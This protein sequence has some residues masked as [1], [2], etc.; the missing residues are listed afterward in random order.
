MTSSSLIDPVV[1]H[2][3]DL[4]LWEA[5][6]AAV[7]AD[8]L[9]VVSPLAARLAQVPDPRRPRGLRHPLLVILVLTACATLVVGND[10]LTA[11]RQW[12]ARTPQD[13]LHRLGARRNPLT[14]RYL[15]P[16]ERT[17]RRVLAAVD[18]DALDAATCGYTADVL[19]GD[20]PA[21]QIPTATDEPAER[22]QRRAA[23][24]AVTHPAPAGLLPAV[25]IDGKLLHGTRTET[26]QVFL[27]AAVTHD[28]A[29]ILGQRQV[30]GKR[31]E[32][33]V[34][35]NLL[36]PL[37]VA[38]MLL[39]LDALHTTKKTA[40]LI[41]GP[42]NAHYLLILKGNQPLAL[43]A[44][45]ALLS[46]TDTV[47]TGSMNIDSD[48]GHG[49]TERRTIRVAPCDGRLFP[50]ARQVF[51]LRRDTGG[52]DGVRT[53]KQIIYGIVSLDAE[54]AS[55]Q[56][57]NAYA[58]GHWSVENRLHWIRDVTFSEDDSQLRTSAAP[59]NLA[60]MRNLAMNT[61]RL[62]GRVN[63]AHARRD[64]H[65]RADAFAAYGI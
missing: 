26:G 43:Q 18:G 60:A 29:V 16:S 8:P 61:F 42:L 54:Q 58:R 7:S 63:I 49:R 40:R 56:H 55:P 34:T 25:A 31:G 46:G 10:G 24:R 48:R 23:T 62:A 41:T 45:Q 53:S 3:A 32:T 2:L 65:D 20:V 50:G 52:L 37:D 57:L 17:F 1:D 21:P 51:R 59:R 19:R 9:R 13:V 14:G 5:E 44:A 35:E 12:A 6:L 39:T 36:A 27:V 64:L 22:E 38:G 33:T 28:R 47:F 11:I 30:A 15:V 4:A